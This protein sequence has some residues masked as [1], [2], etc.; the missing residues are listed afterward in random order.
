LLSV[1]LLIFGGRALLQGTLT[2][3]NFFA[4]ILYLGVLMIPASSLVGLGSQ[5]AS[6]LGSLDR[7]QEILGEQPETK[8][9][10]RRIQIGRIRGDIL[11]QNVSFEYVPGKLVLQDVSFF[12]GAGS[13]SALV[14]R[15]GAGKSTLMS[16]IAAFMNPV[17]GRVFIDGAELTEI[18]LDSYRRQLGVVWQDNFLFDGSIRENIVFGRPRA[19]ESEMLKAAEAAYVHEFAEQFPQG[20][21]TI[22]GERGVRLSG[23]QRQRVAIA[24][25]ILADRVFSCSMKQLPTWIRKAKPTSSEPSTC[26]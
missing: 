14:G 5:L 26:S 17:Q 20:Y 18:T 13:I 7:I 8:D 10:T 9:A 6:G 15:S 1:V 16:L 4:Y 24:R 23:G 21:N 11:F 2:I 3:G 25:A 12:A 22:I 19:S